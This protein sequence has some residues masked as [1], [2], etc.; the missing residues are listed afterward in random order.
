MKI[1]KKEDGNYYEKVVT[2][3]KKPRYGALFAVGLNIII[4]FLLIWLVGKYPDIVSNFSIVKYFMLAL[5]V[6]LVN[7]WISCFLCI[8]WEEMMGKGKEIKYRR[9][10]K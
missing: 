4:Q 2:W 7:I 5:L 6:C 1:K 10:G 3:E 8:T 9:I